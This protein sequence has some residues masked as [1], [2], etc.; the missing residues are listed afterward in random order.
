MSSISANGLPIALLG[1]IPAPSHLL[2][3]N[4]VVLPDRHGNAAAFRACR[5]DRAVAWIERIEILYEAMFSANTA[6]YAYRGFTEVQRDCRVSRAKAGEPVHREVNRDITRQQSAVGETITLIWVRGIGISPDRFAPT[7]I[8]R[9]RDKSKGPRIVPEP[10]FRRGVRP[11]INTG[12]DY[13]L[14]LF[15]AALSSLP[16]PALPWPAGLR[17]SPF[18]EPPLIPVVVPDFILLDFILCDVIL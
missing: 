18:L 7:G 4:V 12:V 15:L 5:D 3:E 6:F 2:I 17:A 8:R 1:V 13:L 11:P 9:A 16:A 10:L 14:P